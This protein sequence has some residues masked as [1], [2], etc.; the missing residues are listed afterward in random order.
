MLSAD[1]VHWPEIPGN[2]TQV[3][4]PVTTVLPQSTSSGSGNSAQSPPQLG[5]TVLARRTA[6]R[7]VRHST[8]GIVTLRT[9][10][11]SGDGAQPT[12]L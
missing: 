2:S 11:E 12:T 6:A 1:Q 8:G 7:S 5:V 3:S 10:S 9:L 4:K